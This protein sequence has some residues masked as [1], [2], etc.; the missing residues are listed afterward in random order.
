[1]MKNL[2]WNV[3]SIHLAGAGVSLLFS[4]DMRQGE[5]VRMIAEP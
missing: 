2:K 4:I 5:S 3:L 1:M